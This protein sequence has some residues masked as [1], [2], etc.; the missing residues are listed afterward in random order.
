MSRKPK[1]PLRV[2]C[3][4]FVALDH[5]GRPAAAVAF[6]TGDKHVGRDRRH[7]GASLD[8]EIIEARD[9]VSVSRDA[10]GHSVV[11][12]DGRK[13]RSDVWF[14]FSAEAVTVADSRHHRRALDPACGG[15]PALIA[16][17]EATARRIGQ[18][19]T[20]P[21]DIIVETAKARLSEF[22]KDTGE[23]PEWAH[24]HAAL[25]PS[26]VSASMTKAE[27]H[28]SHQGHAEFLAAHLAKATQATAAKV[29]AVKGDSK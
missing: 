17:D 3:N 23:L 12:G 8:A 14:N 6:D 27:V 22:V 15:Q 9:P 7:V 28:K 13:S 24:L 21:S 2:V 16:A 29:A 10:S 4:P 25:L 11:S 26:G 20:N 5:E 18:K 1:P 19:F